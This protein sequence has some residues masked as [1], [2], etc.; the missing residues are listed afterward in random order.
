LKER[1]VAKEQQRGLLLQTKL[2]KARRR[3][4][5]GAWVKSGE[6]MDPK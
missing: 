6:V 2:S 5:G 3:G 1:Q 4:S